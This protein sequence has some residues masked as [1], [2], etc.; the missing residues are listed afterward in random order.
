MCHDQ[1]FLRWELKLLL[2]RVTRAFFHLARGDYAYIGW[3]DWGLG[4]P[5]NPEP[6]HGTVPA[7]T[8]GVPLPEILTS[9]S[10]PWNRVGT[11]LGL[12]KET[13]RGSSIFTREYSGASISLDCTQRFEAQIVL[14]S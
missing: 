6:A 14:K 12:C 4:W 13:A 2:Y 10:S 11:P 7:K 8:K 5:F 3:D 1:R 9:P